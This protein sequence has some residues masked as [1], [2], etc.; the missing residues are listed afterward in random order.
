IDFAAPVLAEARANV[1]RAGLE[2][3]VSLSQ[4]N[5]LT[6]PFAD[7]AFRYVLCWGVLMHIPDVAGAIAELARVLAPGGTLIVGEGNMHS[8]DELALR[9]LDRL[10]RT[11]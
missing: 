11:T 7:S 3:R 8:P 5:L 6:L 4:G 10:G 9:L 1:A 2:D